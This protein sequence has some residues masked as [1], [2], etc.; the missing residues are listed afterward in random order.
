[1]MIVACVALAAGA[2][3]QE[4][5]TPGP[6]RGLQK[7]VDE[8]TRIEVFRGRSG[9]FT[10]LPPRAERS[11]EER[12]QHLARLRAA[13][14][15]SPAEWP[16]PQ[17]DPGVAWREL[18]LLPTPPQVERGS[19]EDTRIQLGK[20]L[21]FDPQLSSSGQIAC[22]SCHDPDLSWGDGRTVSFGHGRTPLKRNA[23]SLL[24]VG[25]ADRLFWDGRARSLEQQVELVMLNPNEMHASEE[26]TVRRLRSVP[27]YVQ[28]FAAAY[29]G[30]PISL[31]TLATAIAEFE[32]SLVGGRSRFDIFLK[33]R[34]EVLSDDALV[35]LDLFR[36]DARCMNCHHG[37]TLS[38]NRLHD[39]GLSY[40]GRKF[41]DLGAFEQTRRIEDVGRFK[42]PSLRNVTRSGPWM[43]NGLFTSLDG[44]LNMYNAGM[45]HLYPKNAE[46]LDDPFFPHK[47]K[48][49]RPLGLNKQD[50]A[51]LIAFLES[52][53]EPP[54]R[55]RPPEPFPQA[56]SVADQR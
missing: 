4:A 45:P 2:H 9:S 30:R 33:G 10:R 51:D 23:P 12:G 37:P 21:F 29:P 46:Q 20:R 14:T 56:A 7:T 41:Q 54:R 38:D 53:A 11:P 44:V 32:R 25:Q 55:V 34:P 36:T 17:V 40:Y 49:L 43:H 50:K 52:L 3:A 31:A 26:E 19:V 35:G 48:H 27:G 8:K 22:A 42:T 15:R 28:A 18:G 5:P 24:N 1:M 47:S 16:A 39:V 13:Y 6:R